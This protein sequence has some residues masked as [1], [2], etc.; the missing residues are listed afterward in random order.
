MQEAIDKLRNDPVLASIIDQVGAFNMTYRIPHFEA[1]V[2]SITSQQISSKVARV[3]MERLLARM[4][5]GKITPEAILHMRPSTMRKLG[6]SAAKTE[7]IRDLA[8]KT[9]SG[10]V[11]FERFPEMSD[12]DIIE[13]LT[14][15]K[16]IGVWTAHMFLMFALQRPDVLPVGDLGIRA[17]IRKLYGFEALPTPAEMHTVA[18]N[19]R[20]WCS[21]ACWYLW[22]SMDGVAEV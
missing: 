19:W 8:R 18:E 5:D 4:P 13:A 16:G 2:R 10:E 12:A 17:A 9:A 14:S 22:R 6:F 15:V 1:L 7:Y 11:P 3:F 20:P 21:V